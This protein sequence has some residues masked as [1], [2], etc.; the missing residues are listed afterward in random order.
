MSD[1]DTQIRDYARWLADAADLA[2]H[3]RTTP[4]TAGRRP[5]RRRGVLL[6]AAAAIVALVV[7]L[8]AVVRAPAEEIPADVP[9][10]PPSSSL[11]TSEPNVVALADGYE[12]AVVGEPTVLDGVE[13]WQG[14]ASPPVDGDAEEVVGISS[15]AALLEART[16]AEIVLPEQFVSDGVERVVT[17][18][19]IADAVVVA[20][21]ASAADGGRDLRCVLLAPEDDPADWASGCGLA[22]PDGTSLGLAGGFG[23]WIVWTDLPA[24]TALVE[25]RSTGDASIHQFPIARTVAFPTRLL[26][27]SPLEIVA[28]DADGDTLASPAAPG[29]SAA[30]DEES[31]PTPLDP[32]LWSGARTSVDGQSLLLLFV[33]AAEY[34]ADNPCSMRYVATVDESDTAVEIG[35]D[36]L[37][38][39]GASASADCPAIG[40]FRSLTVDLERPLGDRPLI[41]LGTERDVYDGATLARP[42]WIPDGWEVG[43]EQPGDFG[44][45]SEG[46]AWSR[47]WAPP[48]FEPRD[49]VC[50][51]SSGLTLFEGPP[52]LVD[53][54]P[55]ESGETVLDRYDVG[56]AT[57]TF[58]T[59]D[60][61]AVA[62][63]SW[64]ADDRGFV[65]KSVPNCEG[66]EAPPLDT[67]LRFARGL[68]T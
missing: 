31:T 59:R 58:S 30:P 49:G 57:A 21:A 15:V 61:I 65:L 38:P 46:S 6:V 40:Y 13:V 66:A 11:E 25:L 36:G 29:A 12:L 27:G 37:R 63:L 64:V 42:G 52:E 10:T 55:A 2:S 28:Y 53:G 50:V 24:N 23:R 34:H 19:E 22:G 45:G 5:W 1:L 39:L 9:P 35:I 33:G 54:F 26:D 8:A 3:D 17:V 48:T 7:G 16:A 60:D 68:V 41:A 43:P 62:R 44:A 56:G 47:T 51:P 32:A 4:S 67:L 18:G 20:H 14:A